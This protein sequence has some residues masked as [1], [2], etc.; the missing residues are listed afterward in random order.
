MQRTLVL[1]TA[2]LVA[3]LF[4]AP[5]AQAERSYTDRPMTKAAKTPIVCTDTIRTRAAFVYDGRAKI[6]LRWRHCLWV[7]ESIRVQRAP[8]KLI[9]RAWFSYAWGVATHVCR[10]T[11]RCDH[12]DKKLTRELARMTVEI[13][14]RRM[15]APAWYALTL[16]LGVDLYVLDGEVEPSLPPGSAPI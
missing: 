15:G 8:G 13:L 6:T 11:P 5:A 3:P 7:R 14:A 4:L 16:G 1:L 2:G 9:A 12:T 10:V